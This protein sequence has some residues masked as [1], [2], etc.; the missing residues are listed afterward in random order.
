MIDGVVGKVLVSSGS[1]VHSGEPMI[2]IVGEHRFVVAWFPVSRLHRLQVG[3]AVTVSTGGA[4]LPGK[5]AKVSV[6][7]D[8]LPKEFQKAFA[9]IDG[10]KR[11]NET[12]W[13]GPGRR[14]RTQSLQP[15]DCRGW[16]V[17]H[18]MRIRILSGRRH[19]KTGCCQ[20]RPRGRD[21]SVRSMRRLLYRQ[22]RLQLGL[23]ALALASISPP[24]SGL[25]RRNASGRQSGIRQMLCLLECSIVCGS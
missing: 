19:E 2:E 10:S 13:E 21:C 12:I 8:A 9:P 18:F 17:K 23:D 5:I 11:A 6:I 1:V 4:S 16:C 15:L 22:W 7:A 25:Y 24:D 20:R 3:D 14:W